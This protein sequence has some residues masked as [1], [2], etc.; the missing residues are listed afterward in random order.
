MRFCTA[1]ML[2]V[3][4]AFPTP[5][6]A[7]NAQPRSP[8]RTQVIAAAREVMKTAR[9][10]TL[11]TLGND[12]RPQARI[13]DPVVPEQDLT[14]WIATNPLTRK[15][16]EIRRDARV[17]LLYFNAAAGEYVT[18]LGTATLV[19]GSA[20][21][22][23]HWK[24]DWAPYYKSRPRGDDYVLIRVR[25]SRL[26][27]VSPSRKIV[28]DP[29][30]WRPAIID[31]RGGVVAD[32]ATVPRESVFMFSLW[33][34]AV[35]L[36]RFVQRTPIIGNDGEPVGVSGILVPNAALKG[37]RSMAQSRMGFGGQ[38]IETPVD[39]IEFGA[40]GN[41]ATRQR[42]FAI[43]Q[44]LSEDQV[45]GI[46]EER[47]LRIRGEDGAIIPTDRISIQQVSI[48]EGVPLSRVHLSRGLTE[49][50]REIWVVSF[51]RPK[52]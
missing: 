41:H 11:V 22:V 7:Q 13:V 46:P 42:P 27:V 5:I 12:G 36:G 48:P 6:F 3:A 26:E 34:G 35:E 24:A 29:K 10:A 51:V 45:R 18:V 52:A 23:R 8:G 9:Y 32:G 47:L 4:G 1:A 50:A 30:T 2:L 37:T 49:H 28:N 43:L 31:L 40:D 20:A 21:K 16:A 17:T 15:V 25:P 38:L 14:I 44:P 39:P 33:R 19:V